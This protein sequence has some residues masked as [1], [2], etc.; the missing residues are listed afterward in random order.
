MLILNDNR[1]VY[2]PWECAPV[3]TLPEHSF[4]GL[5]STM[6]RTI[7]KIAFIFA[8]VCG[9]LAVTINDA[10]AAPTLRSSA[11]AS[12]KTQKGAHYVWGAAGPYS[13]GYDCSGLV[14]WAYK[15]HGK[16]LYRTA[17]DQYTHSHHIS[18]GAR[19]PGDLIFIKD[20][21]GHVYHVG[22]FTGVRNGKGYMLNANY[23]RTTA[24]IVGEWPV[25]NYTYGSPYAVYGRY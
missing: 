1:G 20:S 18:A 16:T 10:E 13:R 6:K 11:M 2:S 23:G 19:Q 9:V 25:T 22:I 3:I 21:R 14:Y 8:L 15:Q 12:A 7:A 5:D 24:H 4:E 17:A